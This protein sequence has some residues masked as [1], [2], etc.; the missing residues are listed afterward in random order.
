MTMTTSAPTTP[1]AGGLSRWQKIVG[2]LGLVV[3]LG[4]GN[5]LYDV[6]DRGAMGP[7]QQHG[8]GSG[9]TPTTQPTP[10][11]GSAPGTDTGGHDPSQFDHG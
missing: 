2:I 11:G 5:R 4:V 9:G 10:G 8:P 6:I 1:Y 3:V 7:G